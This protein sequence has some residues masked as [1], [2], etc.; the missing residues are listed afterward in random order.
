MSAV[1]STDPY[2]ADP[3]EADAAWRAAVFARDAEAAEKVLHPDYHLVLVYPSLARLDRA[4]WL[5]TLA[6]Y[7]IDSWDV[8]QSAWDIHHDVA[9]HMQLVVQTA[10]VFGAD[11]SGPFVLTD[12]WLRGA[13]GAWRVW[14]RHSTPLQAGEIPRPVS[15]EA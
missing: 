15:D 14:R 4:D 12:T 5:R 10:T 9:T 1:T 13:D 3:R 11:R 7:V 6:D 8:R 2:P